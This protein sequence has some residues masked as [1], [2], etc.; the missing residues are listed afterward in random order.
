MPIPQKRPGSTGQ[1]AQQAQLPPVQ[2]FTPD[3]KLRPELL[4]EEAQKVGQILAD[5]GLEKAQMRRFY[6]DVLSLRRRFEIDS[7][8]RGP[9]ER[10]SSF[11]EILPE[12][13]M[14]RAKAYYANKRSSA[15]LPD[16]MRRFVDQHCNSVKNSRDFL[17]FCRHFEAVVA[18]HYTFAK[19]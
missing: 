7:A 14:L 17:A 4:D 8:G 18:Y 5:A 16:E 11:Q 9:G 15:I 1:P 19:K 13:R 12:F 3:G 6:G 2:Y 10:E